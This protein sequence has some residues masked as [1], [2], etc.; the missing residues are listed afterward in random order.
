MLT[1]HHLEYSQSFRVLWLLEELGADYEL[2]I[3]QRD[4]ITILAP[5]DY[6]AQSP[7]GTAP[8]ITDGELSLAET[9][10][11]IDYIMDQHPQSTLVPAIAEPDRTQHLFWYNASQAS[12]MPMMLM[13]AVM[14]ISQQRS[15][16]FVKPILKSVNQ[17]IVSGMIRPR[18]DKLLDMAEDTLQAS[19]WFGGRNFSTAD[20]A[21]SYPLESAKIRGFLDEKYPACL[22][23]FEKAYARDAFKSAK[24]KDGKESMV[25]TV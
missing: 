10:A 19:E 5:A 25:L 21:M 12:L 18:V 15:P 2:K 16:F 23:W 8:F 7:L 17:K 4:P 24:Q 6:K 9:N 22:N 20:I 11:I 14:R 1:L 3:Y 13:N